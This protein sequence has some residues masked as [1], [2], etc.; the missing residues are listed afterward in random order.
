MMRTWAQQPAT[1]YQTQAGKLGMSIDLMVALCNKLKAAPFFSLPNAVNDTDPYSTNMAAYVAA[2]LDPSLPV[3]VEYSSTGN[4][5]M[6]TV[7]VSVME[8]EG[9]VGGR[10]PWRQGEGKGRDWWGKQAGRRQADHS[11]S[12][13][14]V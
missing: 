7:L 1:T 11:M 10:G 12:G 14:W 8:L 2:N 4:G 3:Y 5:W 6:S 13:P 9:V